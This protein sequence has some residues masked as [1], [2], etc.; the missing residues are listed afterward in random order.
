MVLEKF[1]PFLSGELHVDINDVGLRIEMIV[2]DPL[3]QHCSCHNLSLVAH[4]I[5]KQAKFLAYLGQMAQGK[6]LP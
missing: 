4:E 5:F 3:E 1:L 6:R 2:P